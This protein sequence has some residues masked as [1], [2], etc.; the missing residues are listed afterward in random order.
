MKAAIQRLLGMAGYQLRRKYPRDFTAEDVALVRRVEPFTRVSPEQIW[1]CVQAIEYVV[2]NQIR[3]AVVECGVWKGGSVMAMALTLLRL[4]DRSRE[5]YLYDTFGGMTPPTAHDIDFRGRDAAS[6]MAVATDRARGIEAYA[7]LEEARANILGTGY[8]P[9]KVHFIKGRV[10]DTL[11]LQ[12]PEQISL[13]RLDTDWYESTRHELEHLFPR[14]SRGGVLMIDD[15]GYWRG[16]RKATDEYF[17]KQTPKP[18]F[19]RV[20][21][22]SRLAVKL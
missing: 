11:P 4:G 16:V 6:Q 2:Q 8:E 14:L 5:L 21:Y 18:L 7:P 12:A 20:D 22:A 10:E 15:Y 17:A 13:L 19:S 9:S 1:G 3:G